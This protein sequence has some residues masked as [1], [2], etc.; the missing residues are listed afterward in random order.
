VN[1]PEDVPVLTQLVHALR[2]RKITERGTLL[3]LAASTLHA[4]AAL[5][6]R[7]VDHWEVSPGGWL[8]PPK[9]GKGGEDSGPVGDLLTAL[10]DGSWDSVAKARSF[11]A[12]VSDLSGAHVDVIVRRIH[13]E[14]RHALSLDLWGSWTPAAVKDVE[15]ALARR[16]D[17]ARSTMTK[18]QYE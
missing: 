6:F 12:R 17:V 4:L 7:R 2:E 3:I 8:P 5:R 9:A 11:A 14:R 16:L 10:E 13:R 15:G 18:Y 1:E